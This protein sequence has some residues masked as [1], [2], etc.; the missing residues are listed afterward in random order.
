M[1]DAKNSIL[2]I[3]IK[4]INGIKLANVRGQ[5]IVIGRIMLHDWKEN[6]YRLF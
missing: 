5:Y 3:L 6:W 4:R 2:R 1:P